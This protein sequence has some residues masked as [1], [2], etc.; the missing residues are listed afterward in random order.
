[1]A[2]QEI[3]YKGGPTVPWWLVLIEG[4]FA[5]ILGILFFT[6]PA[7]TLLIMIQFLGVYWLITGIIAL[8]SLFWNRAGWGWKVFNGILGIIAGILIIQNPLW[9]TLLVPVTLA[10]IIGFAGIFI[11]IT[12]LIQAFRGGGWGIGILGVLSI[13]L[14]IFLVARPVIASLAL[15]FILG[16]LLVTGG[17]LAL[18]L[19]FSLLRV[20]GQK[21]EVQAPEA[22]RS[23][24][25]DLGAKAGEAVDA[26]GAAVGA[27]AT[28]VAGM[29]AAGV[30]ALEEKVET[31]PEV[32]EAAVEEVTGAG[33]AVAERVEDLSAHA[34][35]AVEETHEAVAE[36]SEAMPE[37]MEAA[38]EEVTEAGEAI[39]EAASLPA[40]EWIPP[41]GEGVAFAGEAV[42]AVE[43]R[44]E[45]VVD[46][47]AL[48]G[49]LDLSDLEE[50]AKFKHLLEYVEGIGPTYAEYLK[51]IGLTNC[52]E[53]LQAGATRKG[54]EEIAEK[55]G[56]SPKLILEWVNHVDL[57]RIKGVGSEYA[58]LLEAAGVDTVVELAQRNAGNLFEKI[59]LVNDE[60]ALVRKLPTLEQLQDWVAQA[61]DLPRVITY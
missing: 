5:I 19:A 17:I 42:E 32:V 10:W 20:K 3:A 2:S 28:G 26:G 24:V 46:V 29:A 30:V 18:I 60:K 58:D 57:Y 16:F 41:A 47:S 14:G 1:M 56:I 51:A 61:K 44:S 33:E 12:Q 23:T 7:A 31:A 43:E 59:N 4:I 40:A 9:S 48:L 49:Q 27:A 15:P 21:P 55:S 38:V 45:E 25:V 54:R 53:L 35:M 8:I 37:V 6:Q 34:V 22:V 39:E 52:L 36:V 13:L 11:G 50:S